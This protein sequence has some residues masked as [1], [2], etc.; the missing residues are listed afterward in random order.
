MFK[1]LRDI[2]PESCHFSSSRYRSSACRP[3][4]AIDIF[5]SAAL[6]LTMLSNSSSRGIDKME[7]LVSFML[8]RV[9]KYYISFMRY[10]LILLLRC[11][12]CNTFSSIY[13]FSNFFC[14]NEARNHV[15]QMFQV[16]IHL[17]YFFLKLGSPF[18][19]HR[20]TGTSPLCFNSLD[21]PILTWKNKNKTMK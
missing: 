19:K 15:L 2:S 9:N 10:Y 7:P 16:M 21:T 13:C 14:R 1:P 12:R 3:T 4:S 20:H 18:E 17:R 11:N 5:C 6:F 8:L